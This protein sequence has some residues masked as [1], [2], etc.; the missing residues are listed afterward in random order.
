MII[1]PLIG[2]ISATEKE[3]RIILRRL[4]KCQEKG[5]HTG[6]IKDIGIVY[7][8]SGIGKTNASH[9]A[10]LMIERFHPGLIINFGIGGA[11]PSSDLRIGD[12]AIAEKEIYGD[13]GLLL[14]DGFHTAD[15]IGIPLLERGRKK[16]FNEFILNKR[17]TKKM[18]RVLSNSSS[19][20]S[21]VAKVKTGTFITVSASTGTI[22][23]AKSIERMFGA[24]CENM[25]GAAVAHICAMYGTPMLE[26][27]GI[28]NIVEERDRKKWDIEKSSFHCQLALIEFFAK[29][30]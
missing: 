10:T 13:E 28:S 2:L 29:S 15:F 25:E 20:L 6:R 22:K 17:L 19:P 24:L 3:G 18:L 5:F 16:Y 7:A 21:P 11:Y 30:F 1:N 12:I 9:T 23:R 14:R 27:R 4:K 8:V 26:I